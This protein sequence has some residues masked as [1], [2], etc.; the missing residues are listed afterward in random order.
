MTEDNA[1]RREAEAEAGRS[2]CRQLRHSRRRH[3]FARL[4]LER[5]RKCRGTRLRGEIRAGIELGRYRS[6]QR[7]KGVA[8]HLQDFGTKATFQLKRE[9]ASDLKRRIPLRQF[10]M[11]DDSEVLQRNQSRLL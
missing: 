7:G 11:I 9:K 1:S 5:R 10:A 8:L 4:E 6:M 3:K 2:A